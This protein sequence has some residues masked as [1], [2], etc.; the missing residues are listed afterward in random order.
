MLKTPTIEV[1]K[2]N[3]NVERWEYYFQLVGWG[4]SLI[5][6]DSTIQVA[7]HWD[8][9]F[10]DDISQMYKCHTV[11][12]KGKMNALPDCGM[13]EMKKNKSWKVLEICE[14]L[15]MENWMPD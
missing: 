6:K 1:Q 7:L 2:N 15:C 13:E 9:P 3:M 4:V 5:T 11:R 8:E 14:S 10:E 12:I